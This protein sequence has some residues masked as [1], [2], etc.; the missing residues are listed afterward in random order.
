VIAEATEIAK[1]IALLYR[2][3]VRAAHRDIVNFAIRSLTPSADFL[4]YVRVVTERVR[5]L[6]DFDHIA[7]WRR[8][9]A[10]N[11]FVRV[12]YAGIEAA[13]L[14]DMVT[15]T[16]HPGQALLA[17]RTVEVGSSSVV[18]HAPGTPRVTTIEPNVLNG[19][20]VPILDATRTARTTVGFYDSWAL[21]DATGVYASDLRDLCEILAVLFGVKEAIGGPL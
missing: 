17:G 3:V 9:E 1:R 4:G 21:G 6:L 2:H 16:S 11:V 13:K 7:I 19:F 14:P 15:A 10:D 5:Q 20:E 12:H 18:A 8:H